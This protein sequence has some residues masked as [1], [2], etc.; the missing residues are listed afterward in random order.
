MVKNS[1]H[2]KLH[3]TQSVVILLWHTSFFLLS[4]LE[5][6]DQKFSWPTNAMLAFPYSFSKFQ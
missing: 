6:I 2:F 5:L 3:P 1:S 4:V